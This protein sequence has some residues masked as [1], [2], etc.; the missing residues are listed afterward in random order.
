MFYSRDEIVAAITD[1][2][3]YLSNLN[4]PLSALHF[5]PPASPSNPEG[6]WPSITPTTT[7][8]LNKSK[9]VIDLLK[10]L[11]Y[12]EEHGVESQILPETAPVPYAFL[13]KEE[14]GAIAR[15]GP[16][17]VVEPF[18]DREGEERL[19]ADCVCIAYGRRHA[20]SVILDVKHGTV[21]WYSNDGEWGDE[22]DDLGEVLPRD[23]ERRVECAGL[24]GEMVYD[25]KY[26]FGGFCKGRV[27]GLRWVPWPDGEIRGLSG[28]RVGEE[29]RVRREMLVE[30]GFR[31]EDG[32]GGGF[33]RERWVEDERWDDL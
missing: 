6:G 31:G 28:G 1:Y 11:P 13:S 10:H 24:E 17:G 18:L 14:W 5:P 25:L 16:A 9:E 33:D 22:G 21:V 3:T 27:A 29:D 26:F 23:S 2:Y 12:I 4:I 32:G 30:A 19:D 7:Q 15:K 20:W 8:P